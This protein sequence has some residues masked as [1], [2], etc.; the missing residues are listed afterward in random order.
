[1][2]NSD[3]WAPEISNPLTLNLN[4]EIWHHIDGTGTRLF[5]RCEAK[6]NVKPNGL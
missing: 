4:S 3:G 2:L 5:S 6:R 1:M